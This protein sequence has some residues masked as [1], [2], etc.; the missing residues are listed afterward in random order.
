MVE[1]WKDIEGYEGKYQVSNLGRVKSLRDSHGK[2][3]ELIM[4]GR[5]EGHGYLKVSLYKNGKSKGIKIH[6]LVAITFIPNPKNKT[7]INHING[8]KSDNRVENLEWCTKGEN[9]KHAYDIGLKKKPIGADN[10]NYGIKFSEERIKKMTRNRAYHYGENHERAKKVICINTGEV[11]N[12]MIDAVNKYN[13]SYT[14]LVNCC[15][16]R[17]KSCGKHPE[18]KAALKWCYLDQYKLK[19]KYI[20]IKG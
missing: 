19:Q 7:D 9:L 13:L 10:P 17:K 2:Y 15:K 5:N 18:T 6:R 3:R 1:V 11:F 8:I 12:S 14:T 4:T 20:D 16:G